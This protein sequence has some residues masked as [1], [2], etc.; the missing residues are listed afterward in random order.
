MHIP[1]LLARLAP[2]SDI[3]ITPRRGRA[4]VG[5]CSLRCLCRSRYRRLLSPQAAKQS[6]AAM[7]MRRTLLLTPWLIARVRVA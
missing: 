4:A 7:L 6:Y 3:R 1:E 2:L 5:L